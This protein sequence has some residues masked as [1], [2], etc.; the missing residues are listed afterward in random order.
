MRFTQSLG[1]FVRLNDSD[2][3]SLISRYFSCQNCPPSITVDDIVQ[4]I[5]LRFATFNILNI[6]NPNHPNHAKMSTYLF[7]VI[8]NELL[9]ILKREDIQ[10]YTD[11]KWSNREEDKAQKANLLSMEYQNIRLHNN[12]SDEPGGIGM[13]LDEFEQR[14]LKKEYNKTY[15]L[16]R[17]RNKAIQTAGCTLLDV[18]KHLK[19]GMSNRE[20]ALMYGVSNMFVSTMKRE[21]ELAMKKYGIVWESTVRKYHGRTRLS[22]VQVEAGDQ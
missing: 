16:K 15:T 1:D 9:T 3:R 7:P 8:R 4:D 11:G 14:F 5:Y 13:E 19:N 12:V 6:F 20:I 21:I 17:R 18:Y 22:K 2:V 10:I